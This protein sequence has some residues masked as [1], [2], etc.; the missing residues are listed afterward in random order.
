M[1]V[2]S[3]AKLRWVAFCPDSLFESSNCTVGRCIIAPLHSLRIN[4]TLAIDGIT[5]GD[6]GDGKE[7]KE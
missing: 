1:K 6:E 3:I 5:T 7:G 2:V 4:G